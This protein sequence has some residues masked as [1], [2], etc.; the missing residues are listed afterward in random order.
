MDILAR[1]FQAGVLVGGLLLTFA[2]ANTAS[3]QIPVQPTAEGELPAAVLGKAGPPAG[4]NLAYFADDPKAMGYL[5]VPD[6]PGKHG[7]VILVHEWNGLV[8]RIRQTADALAAE[9]YVALA[10][11]LYS[12]QVG[13]SREENIELMRITREKPDAII[14]NLDAAARYLKGRPDVAGKVAAM[15]WCFGGGIA[16]S[17]A[18]GSEHHEGTAIFYGQLLDDPKQLKSIHH[19]VYGTFAGND[20]GIPVKQVNSFVAALRQAGVEN[21]VHIYDHVQH[22]F[23]LHVDRDPEN[24]TA[25]ALDAWQRLKDY[26]NRVLK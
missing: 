21:D 25:A 5:A 17:Y 16:L 19:E 4:E 3:A 11:D 22:G 24:N 6:S 9:G 26:L 13:R 10:V 8:D 20:R 7:A 12:G 1:L 14:A 2:L 23:W 18:L 15:G